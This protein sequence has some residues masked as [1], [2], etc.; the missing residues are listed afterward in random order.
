MTATVTERYTLTIAALQAGAER[1]GFHSTA[2]GPQAVRVLVAVADAGGTARTHDLI[3][4][5][6]VDRTGITRAL[7]VLADAGLVTRD[8]AQDV[9]GRSGPALQAR[10]TT[11]GRELAAWVLKEAGER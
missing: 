11:E 1:A 10:L 9:L 6:R 4:S 7:R 2:R 8:P 3:D 5:L